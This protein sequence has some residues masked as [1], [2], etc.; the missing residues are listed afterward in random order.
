MDQAAISGLAIAAAV[1]A[2][3][4][5]SVA[6]VVA[7]P[8]GVDTAGEVQEAGRGSHDSIKLK[9]TIELCGDVCENKLVR[10]SILFLYIL[11]TALQ[12]VFNMI[13]SVRL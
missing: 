3:A 8:E 13:L 4:V 12:Y 11:R 2:V 10:I 7:V 9:N 5:A 1:V 6:V